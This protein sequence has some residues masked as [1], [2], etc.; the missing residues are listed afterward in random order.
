MGL[1]ATYGIR[2]GCLTPGPCNLLTDVPG[3]LV[4]HTTLADGPVQTGVTAILP[5]PGNCFE[6]KL[7]AAVCFYADGVRLACE[8]SP[9][10]NTLQALE[11]RGVQ[12]I[13]CTTCL[14]ALDLLERRKVGIAGSMPDII[15]AQWRADKVITI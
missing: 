3:V 12:L 7:P 5:H 8:G 10:L 6:D 11:D 15:D 2:V 13:V 9:L 4:G 1:D 14:T